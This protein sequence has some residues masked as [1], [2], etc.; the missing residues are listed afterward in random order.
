MQIVKIEANENGFHNIQ[1]QS[2]RTKCWLDGFIAVPKE[3]EKVLNDC[4]G[5]CDLE[6]KNGILKGVTPRPDLKPKEES[7]ITTEERL[8]ALEAAMLEMAIGG[9]NND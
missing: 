4:D 1:S 8:A 7:H 6:I 3:L 5:Y 9:Q 2:H